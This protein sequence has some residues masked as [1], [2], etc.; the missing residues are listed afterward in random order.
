MPKY[1]FILL[2][3]GTEILSYGYSTTK[4][5][6]LTPKGRDKMATILHM[7]F[8]NAFCY[9]LMLYLSSIFTE[10]FHFHLFL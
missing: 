1:E 3:K 2:V 4:S 8:C 9:W 10:N 6:K 7:T 5:V